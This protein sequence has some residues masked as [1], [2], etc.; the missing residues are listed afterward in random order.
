[1][2]SETLSNL[3]VLSIPFSQILLLVVI[4]INFR[5]ITRLEEQVAITAAHFDAL[6]DQV[7]FKQK[8]GERLFFKDRA[9]NDCE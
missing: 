6:A 9:F 1:M 5:R 2:T 8:L 4:W 3:L 7:G